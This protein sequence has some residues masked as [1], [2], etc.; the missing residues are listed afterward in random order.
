VTLGIAGEPA[1]TADLCEGEFDDP[2]FRQDDGSGAGRSGVRFPHARAATIPNPNSHTVL[3]GG[4]SFGTTVQRKSGFSP[5]RPPPN[6]HKCLNWQPSWSGQG[7]MS[8]IPSVPESNR[9]PMNHANEPMGISPSQT[10]S[11]DARCA[12]IGVAILKFGSVRVRFLC[13]RPIFSRSRFESG[14]EL[15]AGYAKW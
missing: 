3:R 10:R 8:A 1:T 12:T 2:S 11:K 5:R 13:S 6:S 4:R 15:H 14:A 7:S 9:Q